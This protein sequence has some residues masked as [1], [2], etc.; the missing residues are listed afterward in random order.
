MKTCP[1]TSFIEYHK[2]HLL[3]ISNKDF[4]KISYKIV[5]NQVNK[6]KVQKTNKML[7][8]RILNYIRDYTRN[9]ISPFF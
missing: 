9:I 4:C 6:V 5:D 8:K 2:I 1:I 7:Y 3:Q